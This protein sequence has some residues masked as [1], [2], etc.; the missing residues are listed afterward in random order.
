MYRKVDRPAGEAKD[1]Q[2]NPDELVK[3][4]P[5]PHDPPDPLCRCGVAVDEIEPARAHD[6]VVRI[7]KRAS[8]AGLH[9]VS[10]NDHAFSGGAQASALDQPHMELAFAQKFDGT[11]HDAAMLDNSAW[12]PRA[13]LIGEWEGDQGLDV[14]FHNATGRVAETKFRERVTM[15]P[16]GPVANGTQ[17]LF[18]LDYRMSAWR[19]NEESAFHTEVGYW[20]WD[21]DGGHVLRCFM[22]PRGTTVLAGGTTRPDDTTFSVEANVGSETYGI[23]SNLYL[24][25]RARTTK[26][27]CKVVAAGDAFS[28][29]SCTTV[30]HATGGVIQHTDRNTLRRV[31][32]G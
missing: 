32:G 22:V 11:W 7:Q 4:S 9:G 2:A 29:D 6:A 21:A 31:R 13:G 15:A 10:G 27:T 25:A 12:G 3:T 28:Y 5:S 20:L 16:F 8:W 23:L 30:V 26:Y 1:D 18:G 24:A 14:S 17:Q 19:Q